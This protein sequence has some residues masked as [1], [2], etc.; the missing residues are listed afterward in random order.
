[1]ENTKDIEQI[2]IGALL[3]EKNA[4]HR[5]QGILTAE[6][7][8]VE[9]HQQIYSAIIE[10]HNERR[11]IDL[12]TVNSQLKKSLGK[13]Y[14]AE[15][16]NY[17]ILTMDRVVSSANIEEHVFILQ[18]QHMAKYAVNQSKELI[19][20]LSQGEDPLMAIDEHITRLSSKIN[21]NTG[22]SAIKFADAFAQRLKDYETPLPNGL[23][24]NTS[25]FVEL[26]QAFNG[27]QSGCLYIVAA[28]PAMGKTAFALNLARNQAII[29]GKPGVIFNLEMGNEQTIDRLVSAES[30]VL[31]ENIKKRN[32]TS[33]EFRQI[34]SINKLIASKIFLDDTAAI[35]LNAIRSKAIRLKH[36]HDIGFIVIDYLQLITLG[37]KSKAGNREQEVS[38]ISRGLKALSKE[39][40]IPVI[41]L[42]QLSRGV[43]RASDNRP[44]LS[45]LRE[46]GAIEQDADVVMF[47]YRPEYYGVFQDDNGNSL[48]GLTEVIIAKNRQGITGTQLLRFNGA[49]M[50]FDSYQQSQSMISEAGF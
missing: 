26:D 14:S 36:Q 28:R 34:A 20:E 11:P 47:L 46:S 31:L 6:V 40:G 22:K 3:I 7:F 42:S 8:Q 41:A 50:R 10:L 37:A 27:F 43:D 15:T 29:D 13:L 17:L 12:V 23:L 19:E 35:T 25:G 33:S 44:R 18:E 39:L 1:M 16:M 49:K 4:I 21:L 5:V 32:F 30:N 45:D 9:Q 2:I 38:T 48:I 24:G